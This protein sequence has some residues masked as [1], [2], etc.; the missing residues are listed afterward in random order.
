MAGK[1]GT[2]TAKEEIFCQ[3]LAMRKM[4]QSEA[5]S[6]AW[7]AS[8]AKPETIA[9]KASI[10]ASQEKIKARISVLT[11]R[12]TAIAV[13]KAGLTLADEIMACTET[14]EN[15]RALGQASAE[16]AAIKLRA[17]LGGHL[18]ERKEVSTKGTLEEADIA[19]LMA[20]KREID[21]RITLSKEAADLVGGTTTQ[22]AQLRR[23]I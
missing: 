5:Y 8:K 21:L 3:C 23:V 1:A 2:L 11:E 17:Q 6:T 20:L 13:K 19:K 14:L 7:D 9:S 18:V 12:A 22:P 16:V 15:A 4:N 10:L